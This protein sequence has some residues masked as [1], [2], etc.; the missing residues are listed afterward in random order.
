MQAATLLAATAEPAIETI[1]FGYSPI[2]SEPEYAI[3]SFVPVGIQLQID[4]SYYFTKRQPSRWQVRIKSR[5]TLTVFGRMPVF[6]T[7]LFC[8][9][10]AFGYVPEFAF[11]QSLGE[12]RRIRCQLDDQAVPVILERFKTL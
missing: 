8:D 6:H 5:R 7:D 4:I 10:S 9:G 3:F 12:V 1:R 11:R 2:L